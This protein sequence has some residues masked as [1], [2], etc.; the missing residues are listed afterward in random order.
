[1]KFIQGKH[2]QTIYIYIHNQMC[3]FHSLFDYQRGC[4]QGSHHI[5][6]VNGEWNVWDPQKSSELQILGTALLGCV[7]LALNKLNAPILWSQICD[8]IP[9]KPWFLV[10]LGQGIAPGFQWR[11]C[12]GENGENADARASS[13]V[14]DLEGPQ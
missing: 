4:Q 14:R 1:M 6:M 10:P 9:E 12:Q 7:F 11:A 2:H 13:T 8:F 5:V 3:I